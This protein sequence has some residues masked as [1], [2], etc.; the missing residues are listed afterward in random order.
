MFYILHHHNGIIHH[1]TD[2][3]N[4]SK[5]SQ[6]VQREAEN[7]HETEGTN[8]GNRYRNNR[9]H[10]RTPALQGKEYDQHHQNQRFEQRLVHFV[11]GFGNISRHV[12]GNLIAHP[13]REICTDFL[14]SSLYALRNLHGI[15]PGKHIDTENGSILTVD[16][17][18]RAI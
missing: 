14:H 1:N 17:T 18:L 6:Y 8:Q 2:G 16:A 3:E 9:Y 11:N 5:Q 7:K 13:F 15:G 10:R 4:Q 12:E